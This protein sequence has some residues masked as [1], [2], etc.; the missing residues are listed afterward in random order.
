MANLLDIITNPNPLL[1]KRS[2]EVSEDK[3]KSQD[4]QALCEDMVLTMEKKDGV[5]LAAPQI[6]KNIRLIV[7][8]SKDGANCMINP[9]LLNKSWSKEWGEEGC[10][11]VPEV[12]GQ[13][14]RHKKTRCEYLDING[15]FIATS[16]K[17]GN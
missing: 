8:A 16:S 15:E 14:K 2:E 10:L 7:V 4:F 1:R 11:S 6:G 9:V 17:V 3:I 5:G 12:Y 13:V